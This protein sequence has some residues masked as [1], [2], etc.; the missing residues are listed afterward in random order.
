MIF[1]VGFSELGWQGFEAEELARFHRALMGFVRQVR[2]GGFPLETRPVHSLMFDH[3]SLFRHLPGYLPPLAPPASQS[4]STLITHLHAPLLLSP[5][6]TA[7]H[8][9]SSSFT[10]EEEV[11]LSLLL[12]LLRAGSGG[13]GAG[14][15]WWRVEELKSGRS[16]VVHG[17][18]S[19][20]ISPPSSLFLFLGGGT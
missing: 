5:Q 8:L 10:G 7:D 20:C 4:Q 14:T 9:S 3:L 17:E 1:L 13:T 6:S 11:E 18:V 19:R 15:I 16:G 12:R 2:G